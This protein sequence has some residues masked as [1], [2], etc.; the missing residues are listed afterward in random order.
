MARTWATVKRIKEAAEELKATIRA[1]YPDAQF[2]LT[3]A[4]D[5]RHAWHLWTLV[6]VEDPEE[7]GKLVTERTVDMLVEE[8]IPIYV[9]PTRGRERIFGYPPVDVRKTG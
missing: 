4:E 2:N 5:D 7:I 3:R 8:H 9:I 6:D 1:S